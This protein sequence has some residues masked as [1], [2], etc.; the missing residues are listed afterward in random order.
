M[1]FWSSKPIPLD[2]DSNTMLYSLRLHSFA[3]ISTDD[4]CDQDYHLRMFFAIDSGR[5]GSFMQ[6]LKACDNSHWPL[7]HRPL[8]FLFIIWKGGSRGIHIC[9]FFPLYCA[10]ATPVFIPHLLAELALGPWHQK[11]KGGVG[12]CLLFFFT[13]TLHFTHYWQNWGNIKKLV[14]LRTQGGD[15]GG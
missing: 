2:K 3:P 6:G 12:V 4:V 13:T 8:L 11:W 1:D 9:F 7:T 5:E 10:D 14:S 15:W